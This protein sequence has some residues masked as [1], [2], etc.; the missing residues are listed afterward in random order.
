MADAKISPGISEEDARGG[1]GCAGKVSS[2]DESVSPLKA[3]VWKS[4]TS[5]KIR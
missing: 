2:V 3:D 1:F 4:A 5:D